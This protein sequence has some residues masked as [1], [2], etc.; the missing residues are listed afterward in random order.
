MFPDLKKLPYAERL[1]RLH[2]NCLEERRNRADLIE[3]FKM[4]RGFTNIPLSRLFVI[5]TSHRTR[6]HSV[7][8]LKQHC[9]TNIR[10][11]FFSER[12]IDRWNKLNEE[13]VSSQTIVQ[14]KSR[15][16]KYCAQRKG[17]LM[18]NGPLNPFGC[19]YQVQ[20]NLVSNL[21]SNIQ[22]IGTIKRIQYLISSI[23]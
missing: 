5:D 19:S 10:Q 13:T 3:V 17:F 23:H 9:N 16:Q 8:L 12:V 14:F 7:K 20:P 6:G 1:S 15:L 4:Y 22:S 18:D 2:L 21:V 11:H